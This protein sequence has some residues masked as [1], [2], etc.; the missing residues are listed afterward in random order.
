MSTIKELEQQIEELR[1]QLNISLEEREKEQ[2]EKFLKFEWTTDTIIGI[3]T[4]DVRPYGNDY[5]Y[6]MYPYSNSIPYFQYH[7]YIPIYKSI[8]FTTC[9]EFHSIGGIEQYDPKFKA[10]KLDDV[11]EF[12]NMYD[13][14]NISFDKELG[15]LYT[16]LQR[17][18]SE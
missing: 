5:R 2:V 15:K 8:V 17:K 4:N 13:F 7:K 10:S 14:K 1:K 16:F 12:L 11:I 3:R 18:T 6:I 9:S